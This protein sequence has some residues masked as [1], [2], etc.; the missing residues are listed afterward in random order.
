MATHSALRPNSAVRLLAAAAAAGLMF[1]GLSCQFHADDEAAES[2]NT[3][4]L[5]ED[6]TELPVVPAEQLLPLEP[7]QRTFKIVAGDNRGDLMPMVLREAR[8]GD[9]GDPGEPGEWV[10]EMDDLNIL[11]LERDDD[12]NVLIV[13]MD[14]PREGYMIM[15]QPPV[16][17]IP[18]RITPDLRIEERA[19]ASVHDPQTGQLQ[20]TGDVTHNIKRVTRTRFDTPD[21]PQQGYMVITEHAIALGPANVE[22]EME[23]GYLP[24]DGMVYRHI[25]YTITRLG[26]FGNTTRRT[27]ILVDEPAPPAPRPPNPSPI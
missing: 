22:L 10:L 27:A 14:L 23:A 4:T 6:E 20:H 19:Q 13:R 21:G 8:R 1:F 12:G 2:R 7:Q 5:L 17:L 15:Y 26:I 18:S 3:A 25:R 16:R 11:F 24:G 9:P